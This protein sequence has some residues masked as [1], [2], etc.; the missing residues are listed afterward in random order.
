MTPGGIEAI[1]GA[2][3]TKIS[4]DK[5]ELGKSVSEMFNDP[6]LIQASN[7]MRGAA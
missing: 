2:I 6:G 4:N 7:A 1:A 5:A 3:N